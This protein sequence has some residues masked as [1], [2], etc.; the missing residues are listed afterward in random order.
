MFCRCKK[1]FA[2]LFYAPKKAEKILF[3]TLLSGDQKKLD[4]FKM[5]KEK[6]L[7]FTCLLF[8]L[9]LCVKTFY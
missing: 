4:S 7:Y 8:M 6:A 5:P 1:K 2:Q 9:F 3:V